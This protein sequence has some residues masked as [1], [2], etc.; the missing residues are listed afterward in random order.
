M[1][2]FK[3]DRLLASMVIAS[4]RLGAWFECSDGAIGGGLMK[5]LD[6]FDCGF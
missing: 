2:F 5:G 1:D 3:F 6:G 4:V